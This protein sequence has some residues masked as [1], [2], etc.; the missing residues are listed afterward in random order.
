MSLGVL[1]GGFEGVPLIRFTCRVPLTNRR[2]TGTAQLQSHSTRSFT[3][4]Q[5]EV[6]VSF[7]S[8]V[9][10]TQFTV[11]IPEKDAE[12]LPEILLVSALVLSAVL[13]CMPRQQ[14]QLPLPS[15]PATSIRTLPK[16]CHLPRR[17]SPRSGGRRCGAT[18]RA[19]G[20]GAPL[21]WMPLHVALCCSTCTSPRRSH[22]P[23]ASH[24]SL[25]SLLPPPSLSPVLPCRYTYSSYRPYAKRF[26]DIQEEHNR[27]R[28]EGGGKPDPGLSLP[29]M[30]PDIDPEADDAFN[31]IMAWLHSRI[32]HTRGAP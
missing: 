11:R 21:C 13:G 3:P 7:E 16:P 28:A 30:V 20:S 2:P 19:S 10:L 25:P 6:H 12:K 9:D 1:R 4:L 26:R 32:P 27:Q 29:A 18:W 14:G 17:P 22:P 15:L 5:D 24:P 31:T 23:L 8:V